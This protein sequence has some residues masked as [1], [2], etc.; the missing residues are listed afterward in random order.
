MCIR[1]RYIPEEDMYFSNPYIDVEEWRDK[2][3]RHYYIHGGFKGTEIDGTNEARFCFYFPE[4]LKYEER[5]YQYVSAAPEDERMC[6]L[7]YT[8]YTQVIYLMLRVTLFWIIQSL[9][10]ILMYAV[11]I[12]VKQMCIRDRG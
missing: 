6:C 5:F 10:I 8:S 7:L 11:I 3:V 1:D 4:K 12:I 2:P 9:C